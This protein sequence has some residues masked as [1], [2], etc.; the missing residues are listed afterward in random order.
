MN[1][2]DS[3]AMEQ[4]SRLSKDSAYY[5]TLYY[6]RAAFLI[7]IYLPIILSAFNSNTIGMFILFLGVFT[8]ALLIY[9]RISIFNKKF[10]NE[11]LL[12]E[13]INNIKV[14]DDSELPS[15]TL[16][17]PLKNE[18]NVIEETFHKISS[19]SYPKEKVQVIVLLEVNDEITLG[20]ISELSPLPDNFEIITIPSILPFTKGRTLQYGLDNAIGEIITVYDAESRPEANQLLIA[21]QH[22][23]TNPNVCYQAIIRIEKYNKNIITKFFHAEYREWFEKHLFHMSKM[24]IPFGL[25]GNSFFINTASLRKVGGWDPFNVTEDVDL[26]AR[27]MKHGIL[28]KLLYSLTYESCP[29]NV[30]SWINQRSRWNK[31]LMITQLVHLRNTFMYIKQYGIKAWWLFWGRMALSSIATV[32]SI[33]IFVIFLTNTLEYNNYWLANSVLFINFLCSYLILVYI[34][35]LNMRHCEIKLTLY[36]LM[37]GTFNYWLM[38]IIASL[39]SYREYLI[40]PIHW[41]KTNHD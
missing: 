9:L 34:D 3:K 30:N 23:N 20:T 25:G 33:S 1:K 17:V 24:N 21:A 29:D 41:N 15:F 19:L 6:Y 4:I 28:T 12:V 10:L 13:E 2:Y 39:I 32:F 11:E 35:S 14:I 22:I 40:N 7:I 31:G 5:V 16:L 18:G 26:S 8:F 38:N 27:L 36:E 37:Y